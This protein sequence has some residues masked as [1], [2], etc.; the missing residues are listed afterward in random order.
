MALSTLAAAQAGDRA[1]TDLAGV[2]LLGTSD[3]HALTELWLASSHFAAALKQENLELYPVT[4]EV[5]AS[6][7]AME[8]R[9]TIAPRTTALH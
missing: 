6:I 3:S 1:C 7:T 4:A 2:R 8:E 5:I 9:A